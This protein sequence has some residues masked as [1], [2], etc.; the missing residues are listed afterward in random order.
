MSVSTTST[1]P[2]Q[3]V[4]DILDGTAESNWPNGTKPTH[5]E[6]QWQSTFQTK[7]NRDR[8]AAYAFSPERGTQDQFGRN[9]DTKVRT[10]TIEVDVWTTSA[11]DT[12]SIAADVITI[13]EDYYN[14]GKTNTQW[15]RIRPAEA[16]DRRSETLAQRTDH[17]VISVQ[18]H[19]EREGSMGT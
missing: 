14:E 10:E 15:N 5:I 2:V 6:K 3:T 11:S 18:V 7:S 17:H 16:D 19:L 12:D 4:V 13:L 8:P 9:A 1:D